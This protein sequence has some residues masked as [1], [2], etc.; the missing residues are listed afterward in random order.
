MWLYKH[1]KVNQLRRFDPVAMVVRLHMRI[2]RGDREAMGCNAMLR[3]TKATTSGYEIVLARGLSYRRQIYEIAHEIAE[4]ILAWHGYRPELSDDPELEALA[5]ASIETAAETLAMAIVM[6]RRLLVRLH[7]K[8]W[9]NLAEYRKE[10]LVA[11]WM[12]AI[13]LG[14]ALH[15]PVA[16]LRGKTTAAIPDVVRSDWW[17]A[18]VYDEEIVESIERRNHQVFELGDERGYVVL[19]HH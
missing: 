10:L 19:W 5:R 11:E 9:W 17:P 8:H 12:I 7:A 13:R 16:V 6:P 2:V 18:C 1:V 15:T 14:N 3:A 4:Y